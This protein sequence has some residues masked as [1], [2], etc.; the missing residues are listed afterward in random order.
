MKIEKLK[1][2][3]IKISN[4]LRKDD[5]DISALQNSI[6]KVGL[7]QPI[8]VDQKHHLVAGFRRITAL[9]RLGHTLVDCV[10]LESKSRPLR[11]RAEIEENEVRK[12]FNLEESRNGYELLRILETRNPIIRFF[13]M[14]WHRIKSMF[15]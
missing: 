8:I 7:L 14:L 4:R 3:E 5:G 1:I 9:K 2:S 12:G 6:K 15:K 11:L 10:V 13:L